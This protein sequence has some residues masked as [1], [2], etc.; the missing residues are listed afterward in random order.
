M[1]FS[2]AMRYAPDVVSTFNYPDKMQ[3]LIDRAPQDGYL[4]E[5]AVIT[6]ARSYVQAEGYMVSIKL[7]GNRALECR[8]VP[9]EDVE[10]TLRE[11][12][13]ELITLDALKQRLYLIPDKEQLLTTL[14]NDALPTE[15]VKGITVH[16][17]GNMNE[18]R[19]T[20]S[21]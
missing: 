11:P 6:Y 5:C 19:W 20:E 9:G 3:S 18:Y 7:T 4:C 13:S 8:R 12:V 10:F 21:P 14:V 1:E 16:P 15:I 17:T 2:E